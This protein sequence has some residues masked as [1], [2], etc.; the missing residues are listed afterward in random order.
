[1]SAHLTFEVAA[2]WPTRRWTGSVR[3]HALS[4]L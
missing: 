4:P 2:R 3:G 1:V